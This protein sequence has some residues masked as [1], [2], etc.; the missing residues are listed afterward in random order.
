MGESREHELLEFVSMRF[1]FK[2]PKYS[3]AGL[4]YTLMILI[5]IVLIDVDNQ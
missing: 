3:L 2:G 4:T 5:L 1:E